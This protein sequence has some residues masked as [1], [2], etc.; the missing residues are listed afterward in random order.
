MDATGNR[1]GSWAG[2]PLLLVAAMLGIASV[3]EVALFD[4]WLWLPKLPLAVLL[5]VALLCNLRRGR[6]PT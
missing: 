5:T 3:L 4:R 6:R 1:V 2:F